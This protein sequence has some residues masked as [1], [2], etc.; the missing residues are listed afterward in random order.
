MDGN[1]KEKE[2]VKVIVAQ[3]KYDCKHLEGKFLDQSHYDI[4][5]EE[6]CDVYAPPDCDMGENVGCEKDC[7]SCEK[8]TD[9]R[10]IIFKFR[11]KEYSFKHCKIHFFFII[12]ILFKFIFNSFIIFYICRVPICGFVIT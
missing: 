12:H 4:L 10:K 7:G 3:Q 8:G 2:M 5:V 11:K 6:D 9:E 1:S